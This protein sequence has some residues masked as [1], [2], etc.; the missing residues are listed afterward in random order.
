MEIKKSELF[1]INLDR[2]DKLLAK[3]ID[4]WDN[5][6][7]AIANTIMINTYARMRLTINSFCGSMSSNE[8]LE[9]LS[10]DVTIQ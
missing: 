1:L 6:E 5:I 4:T 8:E 2:L 10:G 9:L 7:N 3:H